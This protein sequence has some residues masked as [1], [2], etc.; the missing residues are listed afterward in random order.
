MRLANC[1]PR[2]GAT[3]TYQV[4][5]VPICIVRADA[6]SAACQLDERRVADADVGT[7]FTRLKH[8]EDVEAELVVH[9]SADLHLLRTLR[10]K[11]ATTGPVTMS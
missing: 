5:R 2:S 7:Q 4:N 8:V 6:G 11:F 1:V 3:P 9:S 10:S